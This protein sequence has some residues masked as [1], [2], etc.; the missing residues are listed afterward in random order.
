MKHTNKEIKK[1]VKKDEIKEDKMY[2]L[3][4]IGFGCN[5]SKF[6]KEIASKK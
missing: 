5:I 6:F 3:I 2:D 4:D 1:A